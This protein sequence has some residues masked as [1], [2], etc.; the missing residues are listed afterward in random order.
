MDKWPKISVV[1]PSFNMGQFIEE[2][3]LSVINQNYPNLEYLIID[4]NSKDNTVEIIKK[5][6]RYLDFWVSEPDQGQSD[7]IIKGFSKCTGDLIIWLNA[8]DVFFPG[9]FNAVAKEYMKDSSASIYTGGVAIG[10][11]N[12]GPIKQCSF[13]PH[14]LIWSKR[15]AVFFIGQMS[16]FI[17][18]KVYLET[19]GIDMSLQQIMD[20]DLLYKLLK[21]N[22]R[23]VKV[24]EMIGF[25][26]FH[27]DAKSSSKFTDNPQIRQSEIKR[28]FKA[29]NI[30]PIR[31]NITLYVYR[32]LRILTG[33]YFICSWYNVKYKMKTMKDVW[34][35][36]NNKKF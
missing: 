33:N 31:Y 34:A 32:I 12:N 24:K 28:F 16:T 35:N 18:R 27:E 36:F 6:E 25:I 5:Y 11:K 10:N 7:A 9:A 17:N 21:V 15:N 14:D 30:N 22:P 4:G 3:I 1:T 23:V 29:N 8:D 20:R 19:S 26:R 2:A 13:T